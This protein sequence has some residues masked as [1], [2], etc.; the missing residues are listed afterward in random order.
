MKKMAVIIF[1]AV[2]V[3]LLCG[4]GSI[5]A[6]YREIE[7]L[8]VIQAMGIDRSDAGISL[9]LASAATE[10]GGPVRLSAEG[11]S[12]SSAIKAIRTHAFEEELFCAHVNHILLGEDA[13]REGID[14]ILAYICRS[15]D[16][17]IDV[18]LYIVRGGSAS[19]L[20]LGAGDERV[21]A[22]EIMDGIQL[23]LNGRDNCRSFTAAEIARSLA[24]RGS[25][26]VCAVEYADAADSGE[27]S[28]ENKTAAVCGYG[29]VRNGALCGFLD[30][31]Q[32]IGAGFLLNR[33]G[34]SRIIVRGAGG[35]NVT[36]EINRGG[37]EIRPVTDDSGKLTGLDIYV[38]VG[39]TVLESADAAGNE[40]LT[41][42][43]EAAVSDR[44]SSVLGVSRELGADFLA[45]GS[46]IEAAMPEEYPEDGRF[47]ALLPELEFRL[48]IS[49]ELNHT[50]DLKDV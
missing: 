31:D 48:H 44:V 16:I 39:A 25:S 49:G 50:N 2:S 7:D 30:H 35:K 29:I 8:L 32:A 45:L 12:V 46:H 4:C 43:L 42:R 36:V 5:H 1:L 10:S 9:S 6:N 14:D 28:G 23:D 17:R 40:L 21:G 11:G 18:P 15:P 41:A 3:P 20:I 13:A 19:E 37:S 26:L 33:V 47:G 22:S 38:T 27:D 34:M 24:R